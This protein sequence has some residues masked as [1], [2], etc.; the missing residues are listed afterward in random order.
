MQKTSLS[1]TIAS[2]TEDS[3]NEVKDFAE[4]LLKKKGKKTVRKRVPKFGEGKHLVKWIS[5]DFGEPLE[6]FKEYMQ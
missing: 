1:E 3:R 6:D 5:P 4:F 2:L